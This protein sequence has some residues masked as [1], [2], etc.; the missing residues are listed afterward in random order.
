MV[1]SHS[2]R[3]QR[4]EVAERRR[5]RASEGVAV[6]KAVRGTN[7]KEPQWPST[8][9]RRSLALHHFR[10]ERGKVRETIGP[11]LLQK[12]TVSSLGKDTGIRSVLYSAKAKFHMEVSSLVCSTNQ[13]CRRIANTS[14][15]FLVS[16]ITV[17]WLI[18][19]QQPIIPS[20]NSE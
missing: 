18:L 8:E 12:G 3:L 7:E 6:K 20:S 10:Q 2:Q 14:A 15:P 17:S 5:E 4:A 9:V 13:L 1:N 11:R 19:A 16:S